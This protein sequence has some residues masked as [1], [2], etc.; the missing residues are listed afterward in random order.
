MRGTTSPSDESAS[1]CLIFE[2]FFGVPLGPL[3]IK[4][5]S[6]SGLNIYYQSDLANN[7]FSSLQMMALNDRRYLEDQLAVP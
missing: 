7:D 5:R 1:L 4:K 2:G 6:K 3:K